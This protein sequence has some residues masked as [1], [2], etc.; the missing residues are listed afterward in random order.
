M[1]GFGDSHKYDRSAYKKLCAALKGRNTGLTTAD[2]CAATALPLSQVK[3][4]LPRAAD[5]FSARLEVTESGEIIYSFPQG[6]NSRY[7]G[8]KVRALRFL[9]KFVQGL[10]KT[11]TLL[12]KIWIMVMLVGYFVLFILIALLS[13]F[14]SL[15][16]NSKSSDR[17]SGGGFFF[18]G[19]LLNM[20]I[21]LWFYSELTDAMTNRS[22]NWLPGQDY[23]RTKKASRPL[24]KA[25]FAFVFGDEV[26][27][28]NI[29]TTYNKALIARIQSQKGLISMPEFMAITGENL[30]DA[31]GSIMSF[32]VEYGGSPEATEEGTIVYRFDE[33]LLNADKKMFRFSE[34]QPPII[35]QL[36][37]FSQNKKSM[38][39]WIG[40][41]NTVNLVFG[42][43]FAFNALNTGPIVHNSETGIDSFYGFT[44]ALF[45]I[46]AATPHTVLGIGLGLVPMVFSLFFWLIPAIRFYLLKKDNENI[47]FENLRRVGFNRIWSN[48]AHVSPNDID[49][50]YPE[51]KP[52][53]VIAARER[54]IKDMAVYSI[55]EITVDEKGTG[56]YSFNE[57]L[58][59]KNALEKCRSVVDDKNL[60][61][62]VFDSDA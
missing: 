54:I 58:R 2:I 40:I 32:C 10:A 46:F 34:L 50:P 1:N 30:S 59:E 36:R 39:T 60:G 16:A 52:K 35:R 31:E 27:D 62:V 47:K 26:P 11:G 23:R 21:R 61:K 28:R 53:N 25:I 15:Y 49:S 33:L 51:C 38:N 8:I 9:E 29:G 12:F 13:I 20:I 17:D 57:L 41:I 3:E 37:Q 14:I 48:P 45:D 43:Y 44:Y 42:S 24:H 55:P 18:G 22:R 19:S 6:F 5:E 7:R 4:L 56:V